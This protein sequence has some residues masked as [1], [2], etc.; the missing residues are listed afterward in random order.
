MFS[1]LTESDVMAF[2]L[3]LVALFILY[4]IGLAVAVLPGG[5]G[6]RHRLRV[7]RETR[8]QSFVRGLIDTRAIVYFLSITIVCLLVS[9]R[10]LESRKWS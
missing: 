6:R 7:V 3:T 2:F 8:Y 10:S 4:A 9:F 1:S 5:L